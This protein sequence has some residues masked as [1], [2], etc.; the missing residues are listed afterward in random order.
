[1]PDRIE[2]PDKPNDERPR[3]KYRDDDD[4]RNPVPPA[5]RVGTKPDTKFEAHGKARE[6]VGKTARGTAAMP[7]GPEGNDKTERRKD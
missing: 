4:T 7:T 2:S 6:N 5:E 1:M 3:D